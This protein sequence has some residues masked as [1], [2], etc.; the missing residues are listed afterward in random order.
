MQ[1]MRTS[2]PSA[3]SREA[4][5]SRTGP[6]DLVAGDS[7]GSSASCWGRGRAAAAGAGIRMR[8]PHLAQRARR[9]ALLAGTV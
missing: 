4:S 2:N 5:S 3:A 9:P 1:P 8:V 7:A 6:A